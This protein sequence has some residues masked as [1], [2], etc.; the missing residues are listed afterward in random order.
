[1]KPQNRHISNNQGLGVVRNSKLMDWKRKQATLGNYKTKCIQ[2]VGVSLRW[3]ESESIS[4][5]VGFFLVEVGRRQVGGMVTARFLVFGLGYFW[6]FEMRWA[7]LGLSLFFWFGLLVYL[8]YP[9]F[10]WFLIS[11]SWSFFCREKKTKPNAYIWREKIISLL[12][13]FSEIMHVN[14]CM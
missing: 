5:M 11:Y 8:M 12:K 10:G 3:S 9:I 14:Y 7:L 4:N 1:M 13:R 6:V 2:P